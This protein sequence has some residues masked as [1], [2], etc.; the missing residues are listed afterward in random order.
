[1]ASGLRGVA[2]ALEGSTRRDFVKAGA[3]GALLLSSG[4][5]LV[6]CGD[7]NDI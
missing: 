2:D 5:A 1:M 6:G 7:N 3:A 4:M